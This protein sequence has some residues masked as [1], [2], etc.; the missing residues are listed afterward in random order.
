M[1]IPFVSVD[2]V[3]H[4]WN[5]GAP[6]STILSP[7]YVFYH[8]T[9]VDPSTFQCN[10]DGTQ[11]VR[12]SPLS[13]SR[14]THWCSV[15]INRYDPESLKDAIGF[16]PIAPMWRIELHLGEEEFMHVQQGA[17]QQGSGVIDYEIRME[18]PLKRCI[19][20]PI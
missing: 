16:A 10:E 6:R 9:R 8:Y 12:A 20:V 13:S 2:Y 18:V 7:P 5:V 11:T 3:H 4:E 1:T 17:R 15:R 19:I 14:S